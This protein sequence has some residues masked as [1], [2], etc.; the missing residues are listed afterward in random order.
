MRPSDASSKPTPCKPIK[1]FKLTSEEQA[2]R[3]TDFITK[4]TAPGNFDFRAFLNRAML[5]AER[6]KENKDM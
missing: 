4:T 5:I 1:S 3:E 2:G 6:A